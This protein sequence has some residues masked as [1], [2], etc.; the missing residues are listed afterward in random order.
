MSQSEP[1]FDI[2][3]WSC[4]FHPVPSSDYRLFFLHA[5]LIYSTLQSVS[6]MRMQG[7]SK[8]WKQSHWT[9]SIQILK[10]AELLIYVLPLPQ[11][12]QTLPQFSKNFDN[13]SKIHEVDGEVALWCLLYLQFF[14]SWSW[15]VFCEVP[16][17][18]D[19]MVFP[20]CNLCIVCMPSKE[21]TTSIVTAQTF[22]GTN[23]FSTYRSITA[24][25]IKLWWSKIRHVN[26]FCELVFLNQHIMTLLIL[27][28]I[29]HAIQIP[30]IIKC[31][32]RSDSISYIYII[33]IMWTPNL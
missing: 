1:A 2:T 5:T 24:N 4:F 11:H 9:G 18:W 31:S 22:L 14:N 3:D 10:G 25:G 19:C 29:P 32:P 16:K 23:Q 30:C 33:Q 7:R 13:G 8:K 15:D 17:F 26:Q 21:S 20:L 12:T 6:R 27:L 28:S